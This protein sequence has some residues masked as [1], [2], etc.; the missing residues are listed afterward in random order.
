MSLLW[1]RSLSGIHSQSILKPILQPWTDTDSRMFLSLC[2]HLVFMSVLSS[3]HSPMHVFWMIS[4]LFVVWCVN[5]NEVLQK[6]CSLGGCEHF[7]CWWLC[8]HSSVMF[9]LSDGQ[10]LVIWCGSWKLYI[11]VLLTDCNL[12]LCYY[13]VITYDMLLVTL[14]WCSH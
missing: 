5:S 2:R 12:C 8:L 4:I 10:S 9:R 6:P 13:E 7:F 1:I 3:T 14:V 11:F